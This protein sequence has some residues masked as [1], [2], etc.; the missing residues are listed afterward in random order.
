ME[1]E[2][3]ARLLA[4]PG[5]R[6][7]RWTVP[8]IA[9]GALLYVVWGATT[10]FRALKAAEP[11]TPARTATSTIETTS[12]PV[13]GMTGTAKVQGV[14]VREVPEADGTVLAD[15]AKDA[16]FEVLAKREGWYRIKDTTGNMGWVTSDSSFVAVEQK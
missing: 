2:S 1:R 15:L 6:F 9:L 5:V 10:D 8:W 12:T 3:R 7:V 4:N 16:T 11:S 14:H 13:S